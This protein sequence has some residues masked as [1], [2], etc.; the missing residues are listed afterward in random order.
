M[1]RLKATRSIT[2]AR[3][4]AQ[5]RRPPS[6]RTAMTATP[7]AGRPA[8]FL[9]GTPTA[10][11]RSLPSCRPYLAA[12]LQTWTVSSTLSLPSLTCISSPVSSSTYYDRHDSSRPAVLVVYPA[13]KP[14]P[15]IFGKKRYGVYLQSTCYGRYWAF[16]AINRPDG[17][18]PRLR[19]YPSPTASIALAL[20]A[21]PFLPKPSIAK[22]LLTCYSV[23]LAAIS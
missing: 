3:P 8:R 4:L 19:F 22:L 10:S 18:Q 16:Q 5:A 12:S 1:S 17:M 6:P 13:H 2:A 14:L 23:A 11:S 9:V 15:L 7:S 20:S 21:V